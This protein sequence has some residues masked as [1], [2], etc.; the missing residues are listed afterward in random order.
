MN[1]LALF[2]I[3]VVALG[4]IAGGVA[5]SGSFKTCGYNEDGNFVNRDGSI[6]AF[7]TMAAA[8]EC[9]A[10]GIL[11]AVVANRLGLLGNV[12]TREWAEEIKKLDAE[13][14]QRL[15]EEN[16]HG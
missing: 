8:S 1:K 2:L 4:A 7:G 12:D 13:A 5:A 14:K 3:P 9:A 11:P 16:S 10:Q 6:S 15:E